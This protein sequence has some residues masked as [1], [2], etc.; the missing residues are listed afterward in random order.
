VLK[1]LHT[2]DLHLGRE[3]GQL[4]PHDR[5]KVARARLEVVEQILSLADQHAVDAVLWAGDIFDTPDP[6]EDW[7][8]GFGEA[9]RRRAHW[10]RP[11]VLLPGNHDPLIDGS[12]FQAH[13]AFRA[14]LPD[15]VHVVD[16]DGFELPLSSEGVLYASPCRSTAGAEDLALC[17]PTRADGDN[18]IRVGL[19]HGSTFDL[20]GHQTNFPIASD[21][22]MRRGLDYL[23]VGDTHGF[24]EISGEGVAPIVYPGA[25][26]PTSFGESDAGDVVL[27]S[28]RRAGARP[29]L[30]RQRV[31]RWNWREETVT[32][33]T[34]LRRLAN[35]DLSRTVLRLRLSLTVSPAE[36]KEV[37]TLTG[38]LKGNLASSGRAGALVLDRS[39]LKLQLVSPE[40]AM[41]GAPETLVT[42]A[43]RLARDAS[44]SDEARRALEM[45]CRLVGEAAQ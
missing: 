22:P 40:Q 27:V 33:L 37:D 36:E 43:Q 25:P 41:D 38:L 31:A 39:G 8:R 5:R 12:V 6:P 19:V 10:T 35:E 16:R 13:H 24:R 20:P 42:V 34:E 30:L 9:L 7:W 15:C 32:A 26:E 23:A 11:I 28:L 2:A 1:L 14:L 21:A 29:I 45:L 17:L 3:H 18:R 4:D 44:Q